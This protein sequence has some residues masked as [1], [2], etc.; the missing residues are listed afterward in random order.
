MDVPD[1][2][3]IGGPD[4]RIGGRRSTPLIMAMHE[5]ATNALKYGALSVDGGRVT[6]GWRIEE[7]SDVPRLHIEWREHGGPAVTTPDKKGFGSQ[8]VERGLAMELGGTAEIAF[9]PEG[10]VCEIAVPLEDPH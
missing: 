7:V 6:V 9:R 1:R 5:L 10:V 4:I 8:L 3:A 2:I